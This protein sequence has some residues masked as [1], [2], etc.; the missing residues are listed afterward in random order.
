MPPLPASATSRPS[1]RSTRA[2]SAES[3]RSA[4]ARPSLTK[5]RTIA[6]SLATAVLI[7]AVVKWSETSAVW[8]V[9]V[10]PTTTRNTP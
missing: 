2:G 1:S 5:L 4:A 8:T 7:A 9:A 10:T 6:T 3:V